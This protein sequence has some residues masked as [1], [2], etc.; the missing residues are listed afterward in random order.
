MPYG[1]GEL[2]GGAEAVVVVDVRG[3]GS[4]EVVDEAQP[5]AEV[6]AEG[7]ELAHVD[8]D[9][10]LAG[11]EGFEEPLGVERLHA[12]QGAGAAL[13]VGAEA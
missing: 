3:Q 1:L 6:A 7:L 2:G 5:G 13:E 9:D 4:E 10:G 8:V 11:A 12:G